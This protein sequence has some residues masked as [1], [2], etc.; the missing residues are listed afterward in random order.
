MRR[1][2][3]LV[4]SFVAPFVLYDSLQRGDAETR[5]G[6]VRSASFL[7]SSPRLRASAFESNVQD[8][9]EPVVEGELGEALDDWMWR[10]E[11]FGVHGALLVVKDGRT[12]LKKGYGIAD[13]DADR[14]ITHE[15]L[16]DIGSLAKQFTAAAILKLEMQGQLAVEDTIAAHLTHVPEDK[17]AITIHHLLTHTSGLPYHD[18]GV[19]PL[20]EVPWSRSPG[21][22]SVTRTRDTRFSRASLKRRRDRRSRRSSSGRSSPQR[23]WS[24]PASAGG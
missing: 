23:G 18:D 2:F 17:A 4:V 10:M 22:G 15:T 12:I 3:V 8:A 14:A 1:S 11:Q 16:F 5:S 13:L 7:P 19:T 21:R 9:P 6:T 24:A 20:L